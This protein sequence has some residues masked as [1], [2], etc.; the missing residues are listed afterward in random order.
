MSNARNLARL[1]PNASG[2]LPDANLAA[3]TAG[4]VSGQLADANMSP[5]SVIQVVQAVKTD[6]FS[7]NSSSFVD[8]TGLSTN[9][10]PLSASNRVLVL[11]NIHAST[12][13]AD[14]P[15]IRM[16]RNGNLI[17]AGD[18]TLPNWQRVGTFG[19]YFSNT[20]ASMSFNFFD[21][22]NSTSSVNYKLQVRNYNGTSFI[23]RQSSDID[24]GAHATTISTITLMEIAA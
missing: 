15:M 7:S 19:N 4:K 6:T 11:V 14:A 2:Q 18:Q 23:N 10:T 21:T 12:G 1:L 8:I 24:S 16:L 5:G 3:I 9:I 22:P 13:T 17:A 20:I